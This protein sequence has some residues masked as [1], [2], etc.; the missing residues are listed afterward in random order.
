MDY[1]VHGV[2]KSRT[3]LSHFHFQ[4]Y[5]SFATRTENLSIILIKKHNKMNSINKLYYHYK[6]LPH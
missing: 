6:S 5:Y 4:L 3:Q 2:T 1:I